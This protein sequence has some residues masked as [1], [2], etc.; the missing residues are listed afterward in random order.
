VVRPSSGLATGLPLL[1]FR[2]TPNSPLQ[3]S[4]LRLL[5]ASAKRETPLEPEELVRSARANL[6][7]PLAML[8]ENQP[9]PTEAMQ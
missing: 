1:A 7:K 3:E 4:H 5:T 8:Q 6:E 2:T 9:V